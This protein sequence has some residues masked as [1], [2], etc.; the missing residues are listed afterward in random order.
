MNTGSLKDISEIYRDLKWVSRTK[1]LSF[2]E[3]NLLI[4]AEALLAQEISAAQHVDEDKAL[5]S[6]RRLFPISGGVYIQQL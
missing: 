1:E 2:G 6:L 4:K 5:Q 3:K